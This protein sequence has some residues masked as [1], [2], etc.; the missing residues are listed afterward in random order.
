MEK[1]EVVGR[2]NKRIIDEFNLNINENQEIFCGQSNRE[3]MKSEHP[4]DYDKYG[5]YIE[6]IINNPT[7]IAKHPKKSSIE[8][9]KVY[10][11]DKDEHVLVA[12]RATGKGK[13]FARTLFVMDPIKVEKYKNKNALILY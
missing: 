1:I 10:I 12:V 6:E 4:E 13:L 7:Y 2:L 9:I 8:Y 5:E 11:T 3:H